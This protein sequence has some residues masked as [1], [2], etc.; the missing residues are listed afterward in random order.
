MKQQLITNLQK[1]IAFLRDEKA[2][3]VSSESIKQYVDQNHEMVL[4]MLLVRCWV[5]CW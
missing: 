1:A 4:S 3:R 5:F 2:L